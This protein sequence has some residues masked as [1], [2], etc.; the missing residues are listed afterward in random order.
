MKILVL[1]DANPDLFGL[2]IRKMGHD[3][4]IAY[5]I[6]EAKK[7]IV[8]E[9]IDFAIIDIKSRYGTNG[10]RFDSSVER[11][12]NIFFNDNCL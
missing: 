11:S 2:F 8:D 9:G 12:K 4:F 1:D 7:I 6:T 10:N 3:P 5:T